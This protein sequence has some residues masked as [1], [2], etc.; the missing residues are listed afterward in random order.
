MLI[1]YTF[2]IIAS[3]MVN[4]TMLTPRLLAT[5]TGIREQLIRDKEMELIGMLGWEMYFV[6]FV[7]RQQLYN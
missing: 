7:K 1:A 2:I 4:R 6:T 5:K 3:K